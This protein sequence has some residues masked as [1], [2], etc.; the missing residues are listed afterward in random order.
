MSLNSTPS[1]E[2][3]HIAFF[4]RRNAGKSSLIN[5]VTNQNIA[6]VSDVAGT[7]TDPVY[8]A[9]EILPL[10]PVMLIDTAGLDDVGELGELRIKKTVEVLD[11]TYVAVLVIDAGEGYTSFDFDIIKKI[12]AKNIPMIVAVNKCDTEN[13][14]VFSQ[15]PF[16]EI[17]VS[18][19]TGEGIEQ[20]KEK[21]ASL[22]S[23]PFRDKT[24]IC[25]KLPKDAVAL[26]VVPIDKAAPKGRLILPQQQTIRELLDN[27]AS[28]VVTRET[29][30]E[31]TL[32]L[33][34]SPPDVVITDS[35]VFS[36][37]SKLVDEKIP[38]TSF[39]VMFARKKGDLSSLAKGAFAVEKLESGAKILI[40]EGCTHHR[41]CNDIGSVKIPK[42]LCDYTKKEFEFSFTSGG[43]FPD[44]LSEFSLIIHCGGCMLND[45]QVAERIEKAKR[46]GVAITNYGTLIA[47]LNGILERA[48]DIFADEI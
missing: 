47:Y 20:L 37:V 2:R 30:L 25:D 15:Q 31:R 5:A 36:Y 6:I 3:V 24:L 9:M 7:T 19:L 28:A 17:K 34:K 44:D 32:S 45:R 35:Q 33:M 27:G 1:G 23:K 29:E 18:A 26:L 43:D 13:N 41:Q 14:F 16:D 11:K 38:L 12:K 10:G 8:K 22:N 4:G 39:S 21:I 46:A 42:W 48:V 40:S